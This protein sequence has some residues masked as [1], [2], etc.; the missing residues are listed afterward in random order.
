VSCTV[1]VSS[2]LVYLHKNCGSMLLRPSSFNSDSTMKSNLD[3]KITNLNLES[4]SSSS[5]TRTSIPALP[6]LNS[7]LAPDSSGTYSLF[8]S[9]SSKLGN[10]SAK[11][12]NKSYQGIHHGNVEQ[13]HT[14]FPIVGSMGDPLDQILG[15]PFPCVRLRG[16]PMDSS[17]QDVLVLFQGLV[18]L[19]VVVVHD[20][21]NHEAGEA[22]VLFANPIDFQMALQRHRTTIGHHYVE[23][24]QGKR[25]D[26]YAAI[27]SK[28]NQHREQ[29]GEGYNSQELPNIQG[30]AWM[31]AGAAPPQEHPN[32]SPLTKPSVTDA[33]AQHGGVPNGPVSGSSGHR[34]GRG[35]GEGARAKGGNT[36]R[37][38]GRGGGIQV[39]EHTGYLRMRGLPFTSNKADISEFFKEYDPIETSITLT[40]RSDGRATGEG[41]IAF[42]SPDDAKGAMT[43]HRNT[44]GSRYIELFISNKDEHSRAQARENNIR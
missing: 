44:M 13:R 31:A 21:Y 25:W 38:S 6:P 29:T 39:G 33:E 34:G 4:S 30:N 41:Y 14:D 27:V 40:Y 43:L 8:S 42:K 5:S 15:G 1:V 3:S 36:G 35:G 16:M 26:Y 11:R 9:T 10:P 17:L 24:Y 12:A 2:C 32:R 28:F 22:F 7:L 19:D 20:T 18:V 37:G 23:V